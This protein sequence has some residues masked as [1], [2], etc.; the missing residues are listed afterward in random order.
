MNCE[1]LPILIDAYVDGEAS[2]SDVREVERHLQSCED[3]R[4]AVERRRRLGGVILQCAPPPVPT[5]LSGRVLA[6][7][8]VRSGSRIIP[9][10][11]RSWKSRAFQLAALETAAVVLIGLT[12]GMVMSRQM[13]SQIA[14]STASVAQVSDEPVAIYDLRLS[15][16]GSADSLAYAYYSLVSSADGSEK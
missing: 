5:T 16:D 6:Q 1:K 2:E 3:C 8:A 15:A 12:I 9:I 4:R 10:P 11:R 7:A 14:D 13:W